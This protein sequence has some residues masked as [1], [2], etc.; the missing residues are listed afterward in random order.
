MYVNCPAAV[1]GQIP[2]PP[3]GQKTHPPA[4]PDST[5]QGFPETRALACGPVQPGAAPVPAEGSQVYVTLRKQA[6]PGRDGEVSIRIPAAFQRVAGGHADR[7]Q[8]GESTAK[9]WQAQAVLTV[10]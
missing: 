7:L 8:S 6:T 2:W 4:V 9:N 10:F 1:S 3:A 5:G